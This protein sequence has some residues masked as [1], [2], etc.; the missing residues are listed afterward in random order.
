MYA[1]VRAMLPDTSDED[2]R[3]LRRNYAAVEADIE[4]LRDWLRQFNFESETLKQIS[5][6]NRLDGLVEVFQGLYRRRMPR[7]RPVL[8]STADVR[9]RDEELQKLMME[10]LARLVADVV[11]AALRKGEEQAAQMAMQ[12]TMEDAMSFRFRST[13]ERFLESLLRMLWVEHK[14]DEQV[15]E[16]VRDV[17]VTGRCFVEEAWID[18]IP[19]VRVLNPANVRFVKSGSTNDVGRSLAVAYRER[20]LLFDALD[21]YFPEWRTGKLRGDRKKM[22][23]E[24]MERLN[25]DMRPVGSLDWVET[26]TRMLHSVS[27]PNLD[28]DR[29]A[30]GTLTS[31]LHGRSVYVDVYE[32]KAWREV[33]ILTMLE[34]EGIPE[35][36]S[37]DSDFEIPDEAEKL[38]VKGNYGIEVDQYRWGDG[39]GTEYV[40]ERYEVPRRLRLVTFNGMLVDWFEPPQPDNVERPWLDFRLSIMGGLLPKKN[41]LHLCPVSKAIP[42]H[43]AYMILMAKFVSEVSRFQGT[44]TDIDLSQIDPAMYRDE[45]D[46]NIIEA[47]VSRIGRLG[48]LFRNSALNRPGQP[49]PPRPINTE[50][51]GDV[52][53]LQQM[54]ATAEQLRQT[55]AQ[56]MGIPPQAEAIL[57]PY[58]NA[59]D[60]ERVMD[61]TFAIMSTMFGF[62]DN[63]WEGVLTSLVESYRY[64]YERL[65]LMEPGVKD[66]SFQYRLPD[67][68]EEVLVVTPDSLT[69]KMMG[70]RIT[71]N[72]DGMV[73]QFLIRQG[74]QPLIQNG[75]SMSEVA[76]LLKLAGDGASTEELRFELAKMEREARRKAQAAAQQQPDPEEQR[77]QREMALLQARYEWEYRIKQLEVE[78]R[79]EETGARLAK[80]VSTFDINAN[81]V[82]DMIEVKREEARLEAPKRKAEIELL[83]TRAE[84]LK[85]KMASN[86]NTKK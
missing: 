42:Y 3:I 1:K 37:V 74:I 9:R 8:L 64:Y 41:A 33:I 47:L 13:H 7:F 4:Q 50:R 21:R 82:N 34:P 61:Q 86:N 67:G 22:F 55:M 81:K 51:V 56:V 70:I 38:R 43:I 2:L 26:V 17:V 65:L 19:T 78:G 57:N 77:F 76:L 54:L 35:V 11:D 40:A 27:T 62:I 16:T 72:D 31:T 23:N 75:A 18:G 66:L 29:D 25:P 5:R 80:E 83:K 63:V 49:T 68:T 39:T 36:I 32:V 58:S 73:R 30:F 45:E 71:N 48:Y 46:G 20:M 85:K 28:D 15:L 14:L 10:R 12:A 52:A 24:L 59:S 6:W 44:I 79:L 53:M 84:A 69:Y 60:N